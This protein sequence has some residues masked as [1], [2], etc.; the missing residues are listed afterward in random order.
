MFGLRSE[1]SERL[2]KTITDLKEGLFVKPQ[3]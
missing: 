1:V 3:Q 2:A